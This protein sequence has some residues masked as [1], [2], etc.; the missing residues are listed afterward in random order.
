MVVDHPVKQ[1]PTFRSHK[2]IY[3][4]G[5]IDEEITRFSH[6]VAHLLPIADRYPDIVQHPANFLMKQF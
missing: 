4:F 1:G 3:T 5:T 2:G 6:A